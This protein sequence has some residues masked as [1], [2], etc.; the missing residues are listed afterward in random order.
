MGKNFSFVTPS[1]IFVRIHISDSIWIPLTS[2]FH[3]RKYDIDSGLKIFFELVSKEKA[4][5]LLGTD[6]NIRRLY[7]MLMVCRCAY[8]WIY[9]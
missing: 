9:V 4:T 8:K 1:F 3:I 5:S 7:K 2:P 6:D